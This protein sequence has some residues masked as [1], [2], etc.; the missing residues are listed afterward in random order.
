MLYVNIIQT[1]CMGICLIQIFFSEL[2]AFIF[3]CPQ[4]S[5]WASHEYQ[6]SLIL[7]RE[8]KDKGGSCS[9]HGYMMGGHKAQELCPSCHC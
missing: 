4:H 9:P 7:Q 8:G 2:I 6:C 5:V 3:T 1:N